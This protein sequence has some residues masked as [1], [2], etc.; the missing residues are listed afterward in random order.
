MIHSLLWSYSNELRLDTCT[1]VLWNVPPSERSPTVG[2]IST[3]HGSTKAFALKRTSRSAHRAPSFHETETYVDCLR[4]KYLSLQAAYDHV[5]GNSAHPV[6][7]NTCTGQSGHDIISQVEIAKT[8][9]RDIF[10]DTPPPGAALQTEHLRRNC[11]R[12]KK[13]HPFSARDCAAPPGPP[14]N[15]Q[16]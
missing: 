10:R 2:A 8:D 16:M 1:A 3:T 14:L 15:P 5:G 7:W 6:T 4:F 11:L 13:P 9:D 12:C